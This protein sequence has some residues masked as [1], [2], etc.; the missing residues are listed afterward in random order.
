MRRL[1]VDPGSVRT[2]LSL[3]EDGLSVAVPH[4]TLHHR[5]LQDAVAQVV[6]VVEREAVGEI[7]VGL[8]LRLDGSEGEAARRSRRFGAA[9]SQRVS[10]PVILWDERLTTAAAER[11]FQAT[12]LR[13][14][15]RR[16]VVDQAAATL[17]LQ[18]YLDAQQEQ[19][20]EPPSRLMIPEDDQPR[21]RRR[22]RRRA[23][24]GGST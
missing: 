3:G 6:A 16:A 23:R 22:G 13:G 8:P 17:L 1:G 15:D 24:G 7:I 21:G 14:R 12:G 2:G 9:L 10:P 18:N 5:S 19:S 20:W 11:V 4:A